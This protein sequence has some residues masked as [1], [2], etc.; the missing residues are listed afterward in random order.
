MLALIKEMID[1]LIEF[2]EWMEL[3]L[4]IEWDG[5]KTHNIS[6]RN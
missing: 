5:L 2:K 4:L 6:F 3:C 1:L